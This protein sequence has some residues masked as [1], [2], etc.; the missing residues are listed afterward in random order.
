MCTC[1][2]IPAPRWRWSCTSPPR[3]ILSIQ[4][5]GTMPS[6][7]HH[8]R[9]HCHG[10]NPLFLPA[11]ARCT[12]VVLPDAL[13]AVAQ[14]LRCPSPADRAIQAIPT[15]TLQHAQTVCEPDAQAPWALCEQEPMETAPAPLVRPDPLSPTHRRPRTMDTST[16]F[17]P[18]PDGAY[19]GWLGLG[20]LRANG[21]PNR[22]HG[23][24]FTAM[25]ATAL[26]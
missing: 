3:I 12:G 8:L 9:G 22:G 6:L 10:T 21:H 25:V 4:E 13:L 19:R 11:R 18:H 26:L 7:H 16:H 15:P 2:T 23:T 1:I 5:S 20:N 17:C 14:R 24:S